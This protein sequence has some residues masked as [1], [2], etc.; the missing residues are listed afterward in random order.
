MMAALRLFSESDFSCSR[1]NMSFSC[2]QI[3]L[4][5]LFHFKLDSTI[6]FNCY[7]N[8]SLGCTM[9]HSHFNVIT[10]FAQINRMILFDIFVVEKKEPFRATQN[11]ENM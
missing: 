9:F 1:L 7:L 8:M 3:N 4:F 2:A 10:T 11:C 5:T 6:E